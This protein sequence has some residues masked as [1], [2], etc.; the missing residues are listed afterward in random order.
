MDTLSHPSG[1]TPVV[2]HDDSFV[3]NPLLSRLIDGWVILNEEWE[4]TP[5][6]VRHDL[7]QITQQEELLTRLV[8]LR[9]LTGF[10]AEAVRRGVDAELVLG[11]YRLLEPI[12]Q[13]GMGSVYRAE[14]LHL[15]RQVAIK[16][17]S[18]SIAT[19]PR[20]LHRFYAEARAVAKLQHP[21]IVGCLD[22]GRHTREGAAPRD[23]YVM[24]LIAGSDFYDTV[25]NRG[26]LSAAKV[27]ELF[28][29]VADALAES[30]RHG[31]VHRDIKPSNILIT[32][33][34]QAKL[35]DFGL[36]LQPQHRMTEPGTLLGTVGYMAP[37]Q[38]Q[39]PHLVDARADLFSLGA[40]MYWALTGKDPY[41][42]SGNTLRDLTQRL[43]AGAAD[44]RQVRPEVPQELSN[45]IAKLTDP[46]PDRR[47][48]SAR[49]LAGTLA[50]LTKWVAAARPVDTPGPTVLSRVL[51]VDD[52]AAIRAM[53]RAV[54]NDCECD[55]AADGIIARDKLDANTYDLVVL[56]VNLP[57]ISGND[58]LTRI[59]STLPDNRQ[60][61]VMIVSGDLPIEALGGLL[62]D[63]ADDFLEKPFTLPNFRSRAKT[64]ILRKS[65][66]SE[67]P[68]TSSRSAIARQETVRFT[69]SEMTRRPVSGS[70]LLEG[71]ASTLG[72][73]VVQRPP[74]VDMLGGVV[75]RLLAELGVANNGYH[76]RLGRYLRALISH[77]PEQGEYA[78]LKD[79]AFLG[80]LTVTMPIHDLALLIVPSAI[81]QKPGR[82]EPDELAV[83][84]TH[85]TL[86][87]QVLV[88]V[89]ARYPAPPPD[90]TLAAEIVRHHHE[91]WDGTGY[92]DGLRE[93]EIPLSARVV[94]IV[95]VYEALRTRRPHRPPLSHTMATRLIVT[96]SPGEFDPQLT[97]AFAAAAP[98]FDEIFQSTK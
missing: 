48:Q 37:E 28:R 77:V 95:T 82:L 20:L 5:E 39:T 25:R 40:T 33:D 98:R 62:L 75:C 17:M 57:G 52:N 9:L 51:L 31:L 65:S 90:L 35:L 53:M 72:G 3:R 43:T 71:A 74:D 32:P 19:N 58:L 11:Q 15:R 23:Y 79:D 14:H 50:G 85:T 69:T 60:P 36:A 8:N 86:G 38:I 24:E 16:V 59:R 63:G 10:Q 21:N 18:R 97:T 13:G 41:P 67:Q 54:L 27:C 22:A 2:T 68:S 64:L 34:W 81:L 45:L 12:G 4:E 66:A 84:Q 1:S 44:V 56:D 29:Q 80:L 73:S 42:E 93:K 26:P 91:R 87:A 70:S 61:R 49:S 94:A 46:D 88:E 89:A 76:S 96:D 83:L 30:H 7:A 78:R 92:P 6:S 55:E 47:Y